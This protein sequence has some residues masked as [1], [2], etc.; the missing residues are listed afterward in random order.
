M[1]LITTVGGN[2]EFPLLPFGLDGP[3]RDPNL[4]GLLTCVVVVDRFDGWLGWPCSPL[5]ALPERGL[6][7][8]SLSVDVEEV[9]VKFGDW[10]ASRDE[11]DAVPS[12]DSLFFLE[13]LLGSLP[14]ESYKKEQGVSY[15]AR[16]KKGD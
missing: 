12:L 4:S 16:I 1:G 15:Q 8:A 6:P 9:G 7:R 13:D 10:L 14:R 11:G 3:P 5:L 2:R